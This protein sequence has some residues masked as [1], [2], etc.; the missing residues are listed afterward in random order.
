MVAALV[1][2]KKQ[3]EVLGVVAGD[4]SGTGTVCFYYFILIIIGFVGR[5][6]WIANFEILLPNHSRPVHRM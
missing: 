6:T 5:K 4:A 3:L 1:V 2:R